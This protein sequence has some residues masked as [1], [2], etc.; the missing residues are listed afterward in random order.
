MS[1]RAGRA[2]G[3]TWPLKAYVRTSVEATDALIPVNGHG[4]TD[5]PVEALRATLQAGLHHVCPII[6]ESK[7]SCGETHHMGFIGHTRPPTHQEGRWRK[8]PPHRRRHPPPAWHRG[9][10]VERRATR[11]VS[12]VCG[13]GRLWSRKSPRTFGGFTGFTSVSTTVTPSFRAAAISSG[14]N[15]ERRPCIA[16]DNMGRRSFT[17]MFPLGRNPATHEGL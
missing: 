7:H 10:P 8:C 16:H 15:E 2:A 3:L 4:R 13:T 14:R 1:R 5:R 17:T 12:V 6:D 9:A 11:L